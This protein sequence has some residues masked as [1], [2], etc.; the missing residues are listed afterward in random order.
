M[1]GD[2]ASVALASALSAAAAVRSSVVA[3]GGSDGSGD[4]DAGGEGASATAVLA[5][6]LRALESAPHLSPLAEGV[7][8]KSAASLLARALRLASGETAAA[9]AGDAGVVMEEALGA[10]E[11]E[12]AMRATAAMEDT[13]GRGAAMVGGGGGGYEG[14]MSASAM[15]SEVLCAVEATSGACGE[16]G[17]EMPT[18]PTVSASAMAELSQA[19]AAAEAAKAGS[20]VGG[21]GAC[22]EGASAMAALEAALVAAAV[23]DDPDSG[24]S[25]R[26]RGWSAWREAMFRAQRE[27]GEK[28]TVGL[29]WRF[30]HSVPVYLQHGSFHVRL[31]SAWGALEF[32]RGQDQ[33]RPGAPHHDDFPA[34]AEDISVDRF[35]ATVSALLD[36]PTHYAEQLVLQTQWRGFHWRMTIGS[37][38]TV[39]ASRTRVRTD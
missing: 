39:K 24:L 2:A 34:G 21:E 25:D 36:L 20:R 11:A 9:E 16:D 26:R 10:E 5:D 7:A 15:L 28:A 19:M 33:H 18:Q 27:G 14:E 3:E 8:H 29:T 37:L 6:A 12:E 1:G 31:R 35:R 22:A 30:M 23:G 38:V 17:D 4:G 32:S 13:G